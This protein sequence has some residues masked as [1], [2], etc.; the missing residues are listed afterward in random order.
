MDLASNNIQ[1]LIC[2]K[3]KTNKQTHND[4]A[5]QHVSHYTIGTPLSSTR[6]FGN[7]FSSY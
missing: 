7:V 3:T 2:H 5:D 1:G 6:Y 4:A